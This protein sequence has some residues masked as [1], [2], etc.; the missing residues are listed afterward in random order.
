MIYRRERPMIRKLLQGLM[1]DYGMPPSELY[2]FS[3]CD[4]EC[5]EWIPIF[6]LTHSMRIQL[7]TMINEE[8]PINDCTFYIASEFFRNAENE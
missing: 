4:S 2:E 1:E 6:C 3:R 5:P 8:K 7:R